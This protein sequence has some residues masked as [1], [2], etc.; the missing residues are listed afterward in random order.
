[1]GSTAFTPWCTPGQRA[2]E[3]RDLR[4]QGGC[5]CD[6]AEWP[7]R[8]IRLVL[9]LND[10]FLDC[11]LRSRSSQTRLSTAAGV[12]ESPTPAP[13]ETDSEGL[14]SVFSTTDSPA[15]TPLEPIAE[16]PHRIDRTY[17]GYLFPGDR[18]DFAIA[19]VS[20]RLDVE[21]SYDMERTWKKQ[22]IGITDRFLEKMLDAFPMF[23]KYVKAWPLLYYSYQSLG[24]LRR[25]PAFQ[26][27]RR[28]SRYFASPAAPAPQHMLRPSPLCE[29]LPA[30]QGSAGPTQPTAPLPNLVI[31][32]PVPSPFSVFPPLENTMNISALSGGPILQYREHSPTQAPITVVNEGVPYQMASSEQEIVGFLIAVDPTFAYLLDRFRL[33]GLT[34]NTRLH[35]LT[36]WPQDE[37]EEFLRGKLQLSAYEHKMVSY[38]LARMTKP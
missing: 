31:P 3:D 1:M 27:Q 30:I 11:L 7:S 17:V 23:K 15:P 29:H 12:M 10:Q 4:M 20:L 9:D 26:A 25:R 22:A 34:S 8:S 36:R 38:A 5:N 21:W 19:K 35:T 18:E 37:I 28:W 33:A 32:Y 24:Y 2:P 13:L 14:S 6:I 16:P